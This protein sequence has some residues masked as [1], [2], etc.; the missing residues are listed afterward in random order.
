MAG[1]PNHHD[2][3]G[4]LGIYISARWLLRL[5]SVLPL[6]EVAIL[7]VFLFP[8]SF[9]STSYDQLYIFISDHRLALWVLKVAICKNH[10]SCDRLDKS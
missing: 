10:L 7:V 2:G 3:S 5:Y 1:V 8:V 9:V 4:E 6:N